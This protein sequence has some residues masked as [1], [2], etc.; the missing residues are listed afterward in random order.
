MKNGTSKRGRI[1]RSLD[2]KDK[3]VEA[4]KILSK[5]SDEEDE[6]EDY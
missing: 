4:E 2:E 1:A 5:D 3:E 6:G